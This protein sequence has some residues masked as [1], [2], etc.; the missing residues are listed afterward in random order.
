LARL[1]RAARARNAIASVRSLDT[2]PLDPYVFFGLHYQP[3]SSIDVWAPFF[4]NQMWVIELLS[5]AIPPSHK[6]LVK[7]HK[8]DVSNYSREQLRRMCSFPGVELVRPFAETR[9]FIEN[10]DLVVSIQ[11][12][13]GLEAALLGKPVIALGDSPIV[14]F[15]SVSRIGA[16]PDLAQLVR[17]KLAEPRPPRRE[18][19][20]A[21]GGYL[22]PFMPASHN[23]WTAA[24]SDQAIE[25]YVTLFRTLRLHVEGAKTVRSLEPTS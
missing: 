1:R 8:S 19:L 4:S 6:L 16:I 9:S 23:D 10:A 2:P 5:R 18:I 17:R 22:A 12:T 24:V 25:G 13:I 3:E 11:G 15:P 20:E 21:Y 14:V 7:I